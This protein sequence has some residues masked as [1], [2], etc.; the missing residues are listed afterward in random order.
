MDEEGT[1][2]G[3][4]NPKLALWLYVAIIVVAVMFSTTWG[5]VVPVVAA[6]FVKK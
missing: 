4:S 2:G 6:G 1:G 5:R 3:L